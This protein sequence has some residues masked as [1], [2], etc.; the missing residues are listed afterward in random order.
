MNPLLI[1]ALAAL[2]LAAAD[3]A[4]RLHDRS[5]RAG[6]SPDAA[7]LLTRANHWLLLADQGACLLRAAHDDA[8]LRRRA[9]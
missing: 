6:D 7:A 5:A 9:S 4:Q 2:V 1:D 8:T 3:E